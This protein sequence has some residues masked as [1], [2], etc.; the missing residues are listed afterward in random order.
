[1]NSKSTASHSACKTNE[2]AGEHKNLPKLAISHPVLDQHTETRD[3]KWKPTPVTDYQIMKIVYQLKNTESAGHDDIALKYIKDSLP[4]VLPFIKTII[5]TS[6]VTCT[7]PKIWK[8]AI[9]TVIHKKGD[10]SDPS[11]FRPISLLPILSKL[12]EK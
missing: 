12:I 10:T 1:M 7:F 6:N 11:N 2:S 4:I 5:N 3:I 9:V 8:H